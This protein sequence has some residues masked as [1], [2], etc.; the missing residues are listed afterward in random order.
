MTI[1][2]SISASLIFVLLKTLMATKSF[3]YFYSAKYT[4]PKRPFPNFFP[5]LNWF[6]FSYD[7]LL[8]TRQL[9]LFFIFLSPKPKLHP[10][11]SFY[12]NF[13]VFSSLFLFIVVWLMDFIR[14]LGNSVELVSLRFL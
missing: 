6:I 8:F 5:S 2:S 10:G 9:L 4:L 13:K 11:P 1:W 12:S 3:V 7:P 14:I